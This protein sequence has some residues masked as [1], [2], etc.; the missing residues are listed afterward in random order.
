MKSNFDL[1]Y[2]IL[3]SFYFRI[4]IIVYGIVLIYLQDNEF[5]MY[6][7]VISAVIYMVSYFYLMY[8]MKHLLRTL[9]DFSF[10]FL[11]LYGKDLTLIYNYIYILFPL[12]N[13]SNHSNSKRSLKF[14]S[15]LTVVFL[16]ILILASE[17]DFKKNIYLFLPLIV[18]IFLLIPEFIRNKNKEKIEALFE[19]IDEIDADDTIN[20]D[21]YIQNIFEILI[22]KINEIFM[23]TIL[24]K[25]VRIIM[26]NAFNISDKENIVIENSNLFVYKYDITEVI[27]DINENKKQDRVFNKKV[28][29]NDVEYSYTFNIVI[30]SY[31]FNII[32]E[33]K[34]KKNNALSY[35]ILND[36]IK[37]ILGRI[38]RILIHE[39][40][41]YISALNTNKRIHD[42]YKFINTVT[43]ST[44]F[45]SNKFSTIKNVFN[46]LKEL[47]KKNK[48]DNEQLRGIFDNEVIRAT[49][50]LSEI[51]KYTLKILDK[52]DNP[53]IPKTFSNFD[54]ERIIEL[55]RNLW[56][57]DN[58][59]K[60][61]IFKN[62]FDNLGIYLLN[63]NLETLNII[64]VN[65]LINMGKYSEKNS[66]SSLEFELEQSDLKVLFKNKIKDFN[67]N[68]D[69]IKSLANN[70]NSNNR[71][72]INLRTSH[73]ISEIKELT[74]LLDIISRLD[75][76]EENE[77]FCV[78]LIIKGELK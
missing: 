76:D 71:N 69:K 26:I 27:N 59:E 8:N 77:I 14:I 68:K 15:L 22:E 12:L 75:V 28:N 67:D 64:C 19:A 57:T 72:E 58:F 32:L 2:R 42:K 10:I 7:Y 65:I 21:K 47:K 54:I 70:Y 78:E 23:N 74:S 31:L 35:Y 11:L 16:F 55:I 4:I 6:F 60:D 45:M 9:V 48:S 50:S 63:I 38:S 66:T 25:N 13:S 43:K 5:P 41:L 46:I 37:P 1:F 56:L 44:H 3:S 33:D 52:S 40:K 39:K 20:K 34:L 29:I 73:G 49:K 18:I 53:F 36:Y 61:I 30:N 24:M 51:E 17:L 62:K